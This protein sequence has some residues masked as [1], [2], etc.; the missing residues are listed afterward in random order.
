MAILVTHDP[1]RTWTRRSVCDFA[2]QHLPQRLHRDAREDLILFAVTLS[3]IDGGPAAVPFAP[4]GGHR[5]K[6]AS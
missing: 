6:P 3:Y 4:T 2:T 1:F 5:Q